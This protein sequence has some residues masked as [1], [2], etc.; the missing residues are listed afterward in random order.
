MSQ[1]FFT[2]LQNDLI[3][4]NQQIINQK[5]IEMAKLEN[6]ALLLAEKAKKHK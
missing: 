3:Y 2:H 4:N 1:Q 6:D 5:K